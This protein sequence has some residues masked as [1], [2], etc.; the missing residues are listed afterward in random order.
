MMH[1]EEAAF[2][3]DFQR[4]AT[5]AARLY[6]VAYTA[7]EI[8]L[9]TTTAPLLAPVVLPSIVASAQAA[10]LEAQ[11]LRSAAQSPPPPPPPH[12]ATRRQLTIDDAIA[13]A[14]ER[15]W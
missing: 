9:G 11:R 8:E 13:Q 14:A 1:P 6:S 10:A 3:Q 15:P 5:D 7:M 4:A 12:A 2:H